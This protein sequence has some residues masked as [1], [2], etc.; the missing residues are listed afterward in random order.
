M[1]IYQDFELSEWEV[2]EIIQRYQNNFKVSQTTHLNLKFDNDN[3]NEVPQNKGE[4]VQSLFRFVFQYKVI[5]F[6]NLTISF[7]F[8]ILS[9]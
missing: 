5:I 7:Y 8:C 4:I 3:R 9:N 1:S 2:S 6:I